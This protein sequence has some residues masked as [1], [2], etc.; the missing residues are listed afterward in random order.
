VFVFK[1]FVSG[2]QIKYQRLVAVSELSR[3]EQRTASILRPAISRC[4]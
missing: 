1:W 3:G 4:A 2:V